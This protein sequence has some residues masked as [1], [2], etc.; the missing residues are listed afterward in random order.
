MKKSLPALLAA[1]AVLSCGPA[2]AA[3]Y[4]CGNEFQD[5]PCADA[6]QQQTIK[7]GRGAGRPAGTAGTPAA[8][9]VAAPAATGVKGGNPAT[10]AA[11]PAA[12]A[13]R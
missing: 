9:P 12:P 6:G 1:L 5:R 11:Q 7:P 2:A 8:Q 4:R 3:M 13:P 10:S